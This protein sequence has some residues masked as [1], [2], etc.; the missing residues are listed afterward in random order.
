[1]TKQELKEAAESTPEWEA[2]NIALQTNEADYQRL[3]ILENI[4]LQTHEADY[5]RLR[6]LENMSKKQVL[7]VSESREAVVKAA[8]AFL[9]TKECKAYVKA[10][11]EGINEAR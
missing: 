3:G 6:I 1:M 11:L 8:H 2:K 5:Q 7:I 4:A 10:L 9:E